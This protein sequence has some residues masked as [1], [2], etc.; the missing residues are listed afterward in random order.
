MLNHHQTLDEVIE[1]PFTSNAKNVQRL[2]KRVWLDNALFVETQELKILLNQ[3]LESESSSIKILNEFIDNPDYRTTLQ[4]EWE[5]KDLKL[6]ELIEA[7]DLLR[8]QIYKERQLLW[9]K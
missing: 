1:K 5:E 7:L 6:Q 2:M 3:I 8:K 4:A 9:R